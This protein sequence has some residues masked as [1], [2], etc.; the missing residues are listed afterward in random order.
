MEPFKDTSPV[1]ITGGGCRQK[2][3]PHSSCRSSPL[4]LP[5]QPCCALGAGH[6]D[7]LLHYSSS[8]AA[9]IHLFMLPS[10]IH[11]AAHTT[12]CELTWL[13]PGNPSMPMPGQWQC[14][15]LLLHDLQ[16]R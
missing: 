3:S 10:V 16:H 1:G 6:A 13:E 8:D 2:S 12:V 9:L 4:S 15:L 11:V 14:L 7:W 5:V